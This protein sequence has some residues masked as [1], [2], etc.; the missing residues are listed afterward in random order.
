MVKTLIVTP[1]D[2]A[3]LE[4]VG[5]FWA[6]HGIAP[7]YRDLLGATSTVNAINS[8]KHHIDLLC[9]RRLLQRERGILR[10]LRLTPEAF[11]H[12]RSTPVITRLALPF[13]DRRQLWENRPAH[14]LR[15][16]DYGR[17][18]ARAIEY[19]AQG[20]CQHLSEPLS[21]RLI[22]ALR[23]TPTPEGMPDNLSAALLHGLH[24][25]AIEHAD[26]VVEL[27]QVTASADRTP[28]IDAELWQVRP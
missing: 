26:Q 16:S 1:T 5:D 23:Y 27:R 25:V 13:P 24:K 15:L 8:I 11:P 14:G 10:S 3:V 20:Q 22:C 21:G 17:A 4:A 7:A 19:A 28:R 9:S 18:Y 2:R 6:L 12:L